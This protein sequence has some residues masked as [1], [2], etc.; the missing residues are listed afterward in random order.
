VAAVRVRLASDAWAAV[1]CGL[2]IPVVPRSRSVSP[3]RYRAVS[4]EI[5]WSWLASR[6]VMEE[7]LTPNLFVYC[8][9]HQPCG[10]YPL[11]DPHAVGCPYGIEPSDQMTRRNAPSDSPRN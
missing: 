2:P 9:S 6:I 3:R 8:S 10:A 5:K 4:R 11:S 1:H 7:D